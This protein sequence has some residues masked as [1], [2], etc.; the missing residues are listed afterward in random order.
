MRRS[1]YRLFH[2]AVFLL[3][4]VGATVVADRSGEQIDWQVLSSG[5]TDA[6]SINF[7][8]KGTAGQTAVGTATSTNYGCGHGFWFESPNGSPTCCI[9]PIRG[10]VNYDPADAVNIADLT[11]LVAYLFGG[12]AVP[13]CPDEA[14]VNGDPAESINIADLTYLVAYLFGGGPV[15]AACP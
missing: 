5:G 13:P 12:G 1:K 11:F 9:L 14:N 10:N 4:A 2:T 6:S 8:I 3:L 15:P 7:G